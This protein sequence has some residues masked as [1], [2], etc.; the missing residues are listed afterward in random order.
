MRHLKAVNLIYLDAQPEFNMP[1]HIRIEYF[2]EQG[3]RGCQILELHEDDL[4][5]MAS[6]P[7]VC[8]P[9][10]PQGAT[11]HIGPPQGTVGLAGSCPGGPPGDKIG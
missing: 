5:R 4:K 3:R 8:D 10:S 11:P 9:L 7:D 2:D 6:L 1:A